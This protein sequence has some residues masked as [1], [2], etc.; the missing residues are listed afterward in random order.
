LILRRQLGQSTGRKPHPRLWS[1]GGAR[2]DDPPPGPGA[3]DRALVT[4]NIGDFAALANAWAADGRSHAGLLFTN[5]H[6]FNRATVAYPSNLI[7]ALRSF[8]SDPPAWGPSMLW[9]L[10]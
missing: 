7:A 8:L 3:N 9:W 10:A 6:R 2:H 4:E 5:P 1:H